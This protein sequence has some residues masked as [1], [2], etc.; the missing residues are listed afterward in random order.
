MWWTVQGK[1][2][3]GESSGKGFLVD[4]EH[5]EIEHA[6]E[7][8]HHSAQVERN[9]VQIGGSLPD[10]EVEITDAFGRVRAVEKG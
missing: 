3:T 8:E 5:K 4:F 7:K 10:S 1:T 9:G 2:A 6:K